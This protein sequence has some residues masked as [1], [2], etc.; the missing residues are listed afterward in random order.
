QQRD[1]PRLTLGSSRPGHVLRLYPQHCLLRPQVP[2]LLLSLTL[3][4]NVP[5][6]PEPPDRQVEDRT[7]GP[8]VL[9]RDQVERSRERAFGP[10][11]HFKGRYPVLLSPI[12][13]ISGRICCENRACAFPSSAFQSSFSW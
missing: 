4:Q 10:C 6:L 7:V 13:A 3:E 8:P 5:N 1:L 2:S 12:P 11:V 9:G